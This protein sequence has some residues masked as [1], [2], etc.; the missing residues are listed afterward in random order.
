MIFRVFFGGTW[1][2]VKVLFWPHTLQSFLGR[3]PFLDFIEDRDFKEVWALFF[4]RDLFFLLFSLLCLDMCPP[5]RIGSTYYR[6][7]VHVHFVGTIS[8]RAY[9]NITF[10]YNISGW[11]LNLFCDNRFLPKHVNNLHGDA[12]IWTRQWYCVFS[13]NK[14]FLFLWNIAF[15]YCEMLSR[16]VSIN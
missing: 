16:V 13:I 9:G 1:S 3:T 11:V 15:S 2:K 8:N 4:F 14:I 12:G 5:C 6:L 10:N 7:C